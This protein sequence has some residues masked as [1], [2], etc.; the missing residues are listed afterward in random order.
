MTRRL[1]ALACLCLPHVAPAQPVRPED[2]NAAIRYAEV[3]YT[4]APDL[5]TKTNEVDVSKVGFEPGAVPADFAAAAE[6]LKSGG[7]A[8]VIPLLEASA[9][10]RC[11]FQIPFEKGI[12]VLLPHLS[13]FRACARLLRVDAR[14][15]EI[16]GEGDGAGER[17]AAMIRMSGHVGNDHI[18]IS[19]LVGAAICNL[20]LE[21]S[22][23]ALDAG[24]LPPAAR[25]RIVAALDRLDQHDPFAMKAAMRTEQRLTT[26]WVKATFRGADAGRQLVATGYLT[27]PDS[28]SSTAAQTIAL[29]NENQLHAAVDLLTP[30][31]GKLLAAWDQPDSVQQLEALSRRVEQGEFGPLGRLMAPSVAKARASALKIEQRI[32][33][34]RAKLAPK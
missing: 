2:R 8:V 3:F 18:L 6:Q 10:E 11:D 27:Q 13:K 5:L 30:Y 31:Y 32:R 15:L 21:E 12:G 16:A 9:M 19:S 34:V 7:D 29:M 28:P 17:L 1:L 24:K 20:A 26:Q 14:R 25:E 23:A 22:E 4:A 33:D